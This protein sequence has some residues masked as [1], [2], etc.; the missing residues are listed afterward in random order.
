MTL[1]A[2]LQGGGFD[3]CSRL[4]TAWTRDFANRRYF[5]PD[6]ENCPRHR[7]WPVPLDMQGVD[8]AEHLV[9]YFCKDQ[10]TRSGTRIWDIEDFFHGV[11]SS[12]LSDPNGEAARSA[13]ALIDER[14]F[15]PHDGQVR[16]DPGPLSPHKLNQTLASQVGMSLSR[17]VLPS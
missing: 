3:R 2:L 15:G 8:T 9:R 17:Q 5:N 11:K 16:K 14:P 4:R 7:S 12:V 13:V 1:G 6:A 10:N